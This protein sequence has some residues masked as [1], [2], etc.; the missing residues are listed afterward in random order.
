MTRT[1]NFYSDHHRDVMGYCD[2]I[3]SGKILSG[4]YTRKAIERFINDLKRKDDTTFPYE[5]VPKFADEVIDFAEILKTPK[6]KKGERLKL[7]PWQKFVYYNLYSFTHKKDNGKRRYRNGYLEVGRKAGKTTGILIPTILYDFLHTDAAESFFVARGLTQATQFYKELISTYKK[8]FKVNPRDTVITEGYGI[9]DKKR[10]GY[11]KF[12]SSDT[13]E[14]DG[15]QNSWSVFDEYHGWTSNNLLTAHQY[16]GNA[17]DNSMVLII[18]SAGLDISGPCYAENT[19]AKKVLNGV[20][21][22]DEYFTIIYAYD[23]PEDDWKDPNNFI[24]CNPSLGTIVKHETLLSNLQNAISTPYKQNDFK[25]KNCGIWSNSASGWI[26]LQKWDTEIRNT[27]FDIRDFEGCDCFGGLDLASNLDLNAYTKVFVRDGL[28]YFHHTFYVPFE[29]V[30]ERYLHENIN[31]L[32]WIEKGLV[33]TTPG[34]TVNYDFIEKDILEDNERF[35]ILEF[36]YDRWNSNK[37]IENLDSKM[38]KTEFVQFQQNIGNISGPSKDY[39]RLIYEEK[40]V[41]PNPVMKWMVGNV[42]LYVDPNGNYKPLKKNKSSNNRIDGVISSIMAL[43]RARANDLP[44]KRHITEKDLDFVKRSL[45][46]V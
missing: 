39:E 5:L 25:A 12:F 30:N 1:T 10:D 43:S 6:L 24:K 14:T 22:D 41:D 36:A 29:T 27:A 15:F 7:L 4:R 9:H 44:A 3:L 23:F 2:D 21:T 33:K 46:M 31:I 42:E 45:A 34:S 11:I 17:R 18:T 38:P 13:K 32:E 16:G 28:Y 19:E 40:T 37:L 26:P 20:K 8:T 35:N